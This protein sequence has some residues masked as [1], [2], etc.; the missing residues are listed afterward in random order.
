[1]VKAVELDNAVPP[2]DA[3]YHCMLVPVAVKLATVALLQ[4][5]WEVLPV[6]AAGAFIVTVTSSLVALSQPFKV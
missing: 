3:A 5:V 4:K 6:G 1:M 2:V